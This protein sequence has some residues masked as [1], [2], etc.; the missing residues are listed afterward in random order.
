MAKL[1]PSKSIPTASSKSE[2]W[3]QWHKDLKKIFNKKKANSI[4]LYAWAKR[5]GINSPANTSGL[6]DYMEGQGVNITTTTLENI[7]DTIGDVLGFGLGI[8]KVIL[9]GGL[10]ITGL[11]LIGILVKLFRNPNQKLNITALPVPPQITQ[12]K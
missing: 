6:R 5:G 4:W 12:A 9:I 1:D 7:T 11:I 10:S 8:G 3:I 2:N